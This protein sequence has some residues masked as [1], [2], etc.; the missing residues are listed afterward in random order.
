MIEQ[1]KLRIREIPYN[2]TSYTDREIVYRYL[3]K[4]AWNVI[5]GLR[6]TR[7]TGISA[8]ML[9]EVLGDMW[10]I[11]RNP[12]LQDDLLGN[13]RRWK[14]LRDA[15]QHRLEQIRKRANGNEQALWLADRTDVAIREFEKWL[16]EQQ[17][18]REKALHAFSRVTR[19]DNVE[20]GG[21]ARVS[22]VTDASDWRVEYPFCVVS[23]DSETEVAAIVRLCIALNL[24]I[25]P[26]GGG[27]GYTGSALPLQKNCVI[28][29]TEKLMDLGQVEEIALP[30]VETAVATIRAGAGVVTD[31][32][33]R[34]AEQHG[35]IFAVDP[36]SHTASTIGGN[37]SMNAG[38]KKAVAWG[39]A[40]DNLFS[41]TMVNP[42]GQWI[43]VERHNHNLGRIHDQEKV[44]FRV[45]P[46]KD[47]GVT[48]SGEGEV[49]SVP[50]TMFRK[51]GLG[52]DVTDKFLAG[53]PGIQKEGCDGIITSA[54]F[55]L[56]KKPAHI[57]T[58][59]L[60]FFGDDLS[61][62]VPAIVEIKNEMDQDS[63]VILLGLEHLDERY[64]RAVNY[65]TKAP[66][67][68]TPKMILLADVGSDSEED[69]NRAALSIVHMANRRGGEGFIAVTPEARSN[70][71]KD[72][73]R[74]AAIAAH[75]NA[76]KINE[77]VV[78]PIEALDRYNRGIERMNI[79]QS[80]L[81][82]IRMIDEVLTYLASAMPEL[83][84]AR[85]YERSEESDSLFG[86]KREAARV[87]LHK[88]RG[89][90]QRMMDHLDQ[91]AS[92][93]EG[94]VEDAFMESSTSNQQVIDLMLRRE[95]RVS[96]RKEVEA[97]L[98]EI[99]SGNRLTAVRDRLDAIHAHVRSSRLFV[100]TH[101]H[102]GDGNVHTNIPVNSNDYEMLGESHRLVDRIME[103]ALSLGGVI[104]GEHGI[105]ITKIKYL[106]PAKIEEFR[107]YKKRVDP[108][109]RFNPGK[110]TGEEMESGLERAYTPS[111]RLLEREALLLEASDLGALNEDIKNCLRCGKCKPVC[112]THNPR[113]NLLY[114][115]RNK[116]L[117]TGL[118][119]EAFL[120]EEQTRRGISL[121]HF[122]EM[123]D[124]A[125][126]CTICHKCFTPCP[127]NIDFG[128]VSIRMR[129]ILEDLD[130]KHS[131]IV[132]SMAMQFLNVTGPSS[133]RFLRSFALKP[134]FIAQRFAHRLLRAT[135]LL[136]KSP[137]P[138]TTGPLHFAE[139]VDHSLQKPLPP[140]KGHDLRAMLEL[141][142]PRYVTII[143]HPGKVNDDSDVVFYFPG[144]GSERITPEIGLAT[145][146]MLFELGVQTV[147]PPEYVC[148]GFPQKST[149]QRELATR[150]TVDNRVLF[151]RVANTLNYLDIKT[152]LVSCGTCMDQLLHYDFESI[153]PGSRLLD[154]HE[155]LMEKGVSLKKETSAGTGRESSY[156]Y[157][158]PCHTPMKT[159]RPISVANELMGG[160]VLLSDR[161]CG[162][163]GTMA[164]SRPDISTQVRYR[165]EEE[166][167][168]GI[169]ALTGQKTAHNGNVKML[170]SC[171]AC[172]LG[173]NRYRL[174]TG[175][176]ATFIVEELIRSIHGK[177]WK[178]KALEGIQNNGIERV[179]L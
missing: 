34:L 64:V 33:I 65:T 166:I 55:I 102:A 109:D 18:L 151:H 53:I 35:N 39:T 122:D 26:R 89:R 177:D 105:G 167:R 84:S 10:V 143:R 103:L 90:W 48:A 44:T 24:S 80:T 12:F 133:V 92:M 6:S 171:P 17:K 40:L 178:R 156:L 54:V 32:V 94:Y 137:P 13:Q 123:N 79:E 152:V 22:H 11:S 47:D 144:C 25:I 87:L 139:R 82:K 85:E 153:F 42:D 27:T 62:A 146:G 63:A 110:L 176:E 164:V 31:Q 23:P 174:D 61:L 154:I 107:K 168:N 147:I 118:L 113:S 19:K 41:W 100:A 149:G 38:G 2:Y 111:L 95:L 128:E 106:D 46:L 78:I 169:E 51:K 14:S 3:G 70:F 98:K 140:L 150:I 159:Y 170:T 69:V 15:L 119:I 57:R 99:F 163:A 49:I 56:H 134:G 75:T 165:K 141:D 81:N 97:P 66:R 7:R 21:L 68:D 96:Y 129:T 77:D 157:H 9:F 28:I 52:K 160:G 29:N 172:I 1:D 161:C 83:N 155:Y 37:I 76:F 138:S 145:I 43:R 148:C 136:K 116:I 179:L 131:S 130:Q 20:F 50:G 115:P 5:N 112:N 173:L 88:V 126:H 175:V 4:E 158:D 73:S 86:A 93:L 101:M 91:P 58:I 36:T 127:V 121:H 124:V 30:G 117:G 60:E 125:D 59:C 74:T 16:G 120:Y 114:S 108:H 162:E 135:H 142:D 8:R 72:R 45:I 71:W 132:S 104:S 67:R